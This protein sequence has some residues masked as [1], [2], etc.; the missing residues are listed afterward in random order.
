MP[1][2]GRVAQRPRDRVLRRPSSREPDSRPQP[3]PRRSDDDATLPAN[4]SLRYSPPNHASLFQ[5]KCSYRLPFPALIVNDAAK[6]VR[7]VVLAKGRLWWLLKSTG[8]KFAL[9]VAFSII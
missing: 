1:G 5:N 6:S 7:G 3:T 2:G 9:V 8:A 4:C